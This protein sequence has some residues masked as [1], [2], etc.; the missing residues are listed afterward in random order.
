[1]N[2]KGITVK[3][4]VLIRALWGY[5][6]ALP[7]PLW[8]PVGVLDNAPMTW[9]TCGSREP[10]TRTHR[11]HGRPGLQPLLAFVRGPWA[12]CCPWQCD[13]VNSPEITVVNTSSNSTYLV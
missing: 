7:I 2:T 5:Y 10:G 4:N 6:F 1:M 9:A 13:R 12:L 3:T 8:C 11:L